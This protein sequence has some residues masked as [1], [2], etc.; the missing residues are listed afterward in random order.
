MG[1]CAIGQAVP[2]V[3]KDHSAF[4]T[5]GTVHPVTQHHILEDLNLHEY[6]MRTSKVVQTNIL[7]TVFPKIIL[8]KLFNMK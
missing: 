7:V 5:A 6:C 4:K 8:I 1:S 3:L 2:A